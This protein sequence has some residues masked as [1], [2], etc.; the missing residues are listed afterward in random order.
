MFYDFLGI[1]NDRE[2]PQRF[3]ILKMPT[4]PFVIEES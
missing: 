4:C 1:I 2:L 3:S